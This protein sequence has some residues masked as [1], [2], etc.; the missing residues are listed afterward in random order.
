MK[1][2]VTRH[3]Q[4]RR[5]AIDTVC[6]GAT[7]MPLSDVGKQQAKQLAENVVGRDIDLIIASP[8]IRAQ[9]T[10]KF[11]AE[12]IGVPIITDSRLAERNYGRYEGHYRTE[13]GY[14]VAKR[15]FADKLGTGESLLQVAARLYPCLDEIKEKYSDKTVLIVCHAS[16]MRVLNSYFVDLTNEE[17]FQFNVDNCQLVEYEL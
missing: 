16:L 15:Q 14:I 8:L 4:T 5:N 12:K 11:V 1:L 2:Y 7:D 13:P 9:Q 10:A 6:G 3:G 17:F